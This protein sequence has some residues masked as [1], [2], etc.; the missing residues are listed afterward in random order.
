[1]EQEFGRCGTVTD[2]S[3]ETGSHQ[4]QHSRWLTKVASCLFTG[5]QKM[6]PEMK[7]SKSSVV[8]ELLL[9]PTTPAKAMLSSPWEAQARLKRL[10]GKCTKLMFLDKHS[11]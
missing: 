3:W 1:M 8:V 9:T 6:C 10:S 2:M 11:R 4:T 7:W 5:F